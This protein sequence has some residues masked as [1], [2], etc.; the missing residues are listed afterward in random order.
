MATSPA[1]IS[2]G[3]R[4]PDRTFLAIGLPGRAATSACA[5]RAIVP[6]SAS[7]ARSPA[8]FIGSRIRPIALQVGA[9]SIGRVPA[10]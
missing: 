9:G 7:A 3:I 6:R 10:A 5:R 1:K 2:A 8:F 4:P